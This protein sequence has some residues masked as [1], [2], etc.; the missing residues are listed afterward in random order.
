MLCYTEMLCKTMWRKFGLYYNSDSICDPSW[1][2]VNTH[3]LILL[4]YLT[5]NCFPSKILLHSVCRWGWTQHMFNPLL[6]HHYLLCDEVIEVKKS[7]YFRGLIWD[8]SE[9]I[10][11]HMH[12]FWWVTTGLVA[13]GSITIPVYHLGNL[14]F[15]DH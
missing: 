2:P 12:H 1:I 10:H 13:T 4:L 15:V 5:S 11:H 7:T 14:K 9:L 8:T 6:S 3:S